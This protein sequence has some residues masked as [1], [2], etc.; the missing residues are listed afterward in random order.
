[1]NACVCACVSVCAPPVAVLHSTSVANSGSGAVF[2]GHVD[3]G[4]EEPPRPA[5]PSSADNPPRVG[6]DPGVERG[7]EGVVA[8]T[9]SFSHN[10]WTASNTET[11]EMIQKW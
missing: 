4:L 3:C 6:P 7:E 11:V 5:G 10:T 9:S 2:C 8:P 1:M